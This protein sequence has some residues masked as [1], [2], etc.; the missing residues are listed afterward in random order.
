MKCFICQ[1]CSFYLLT[2]EKSSNI[3]RQRNL[4][5]S[6]LNL[7][8]FLVSIA[9]M[10]FVGVVG[11]KMVKKKWDFKVSI[12][13]SFL[14]LVVAMFFVAASDHHADEYVSS[15]VPH[16]WKEIIVSSENIED[17]SRGR[18]LEGSYFLGI[19]NTRERETFRYTSLSDD[20]TRARKKLYTSDCYILKAGEKQQVLYVKNVRI[21]K[22]EADRKFFK[23]MYDSKHGFYKVYIL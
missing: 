23:N 1:P 2:L 3:K 8:V 12:F 16:E 6:T 7:I 10:Y 21:Y 14:A 13:Q 22:N 18:E 15:Y 17:I 4:V 5:M 11:D 20:G 9:G 19:G